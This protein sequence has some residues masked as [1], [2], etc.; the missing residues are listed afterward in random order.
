VPRTKSKSQAKIWTNPPERLTNSHIR[1]LLALASEAATGHLVR[2]LKRASS[3]AITWPEE[4]SVLAREGRTLT[5]LESVGPYLEKLILNWLRD[6]PPVPPPPSLRSE[7][8]TL[9][10]AHA[11]LIQKPA[12]RR[13]LR[14]D[15]QMHTTWSDGRGSVMD[16]ARAGEERGYEYIGVTDHSKGLAI[17]GGINEEQ[18]DRQAADIVEVNTQLAKEGS[19][20]RVLHSLEMNLSP[21]GE[22]DMSRESLAKLDLVL[23][24]FHSK[25]RKKE[26]QT[27]RYLQALQNPDIQVLG[28]PRGRIYNFRLGLQADWRKV[29]AK[30]A[31]LD[32]AVE[33][34][35]YPDRQDLSGDLLKL[36]RI[37]GVRI[38]LG[39]DSHAPYQLAHLDLA[40]AAAIKARIPMNRIINFMSREDLLEWAS[41]VRRGARR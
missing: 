11:L 1:E 2:A 40:L 20:L 13:K 34:D 10:Q 32:K 41:N 7:F 29:F 27:Q 17:A 23:G 18:L 25:L 8:L 16:M 36:A 28:H 19:P 5:E 14:G 33:I 30:A 9:V 39:S 4:A 35:G 24:S 15:L 6:P 3:A 22:G 26:D 37:A 21:E 38:S 12:W 31:E